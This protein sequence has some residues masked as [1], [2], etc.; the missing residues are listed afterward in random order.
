MLD[1]HFFLRF[2]ILGVAL[3]MWVLW[4]LGCG[5]T[6][7]NWEA[8]AHLCNRSRSYVIS[9]HCASQ[10]IVR[11]SCRAHESVLIPCRIFQ[12]AWELVGWDSGDENSLCLIPELH[13]YLSWKLTGTDSAQGTRLSLIH[14]SRGN[15][16]KG[17]RW[18]LCMITL[19]PRGPM[20]TW[21]YLIGP[22]KCSHAE[23]SG[24]NIGCRKS[25]RVIPV[26][27]INRSHIFL[28][29][30]SVI[31][32]NIDKKCAFNV[33]MARWAVLRRGRLVSKGWYSTFQMYPKGFFY[34][35]LASFSNILRSTSW[36][37]GFIRVVISLYANIWCEYLR[38]L[39][40]AT[41]MALESQ[42]YA[43]MRYW[44]PLRERIG[45]IPVSFV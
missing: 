12:C 20:G 30:Y 13:W 39:K 41:R 11:A 22:L 1:L 9:L 40:G 7:F 8:S 25:L 43:I 21:L 31:P 17:G 29:E 16:R 26:L 27:V 5:G 24:F 6:V 15:P 14:T 10:V 38:D 3:W 37:R 36:L 32:M 34:S 23:V 19:Q 45:D 18:F 28:R 42:W 44:L 35:A 4:W 2:P 33:W